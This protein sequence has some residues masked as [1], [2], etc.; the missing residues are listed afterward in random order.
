MIRGRGTSYTRLRGASEEVLSRAFAGAWPAKLAHALGWQ[1]G[2]H[3]IRHD[4]RAARWRGAPLTIG[5]ASDFHAGPTTHERQLAS[6]C[7]ALAAASPDVVLLGGDF[8]LFDAKHVDALAPH[9]ARLSPPLGKF[10]VM[11]NHDLWADD[12]RIVRALEG[13]GVRVLVNEP[14]T[15]APPFDHV[16]IVGLDEPWT[17]APDAVAA[18]ASDAPVRV[19]LMHSPDGLLHARAERFDLALCGHTHGG[20][21]ALPSGV[22]IVVPGPLGRRHA[23]GRFDFGD[24]T[25]VVSR[26]VGGSE[27]PFRTYAPPDVLVCRLGHEAVQRGPVQ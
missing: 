27:V 18:F 5:F 4:V 20:H 2:V 9:L 8:V 25:L 21:V 15:L 23:H 11:G 6:A 1:S 12:R 19:L 3:V 17:G 13:A 24:R 10:A 16:A 22:P 26:G 7:D 14:V